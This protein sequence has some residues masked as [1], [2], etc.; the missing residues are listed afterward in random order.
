MFAPKDRNPINFVS[1]DDL[2]G[3]G[4]QPLVVA[5]H[6]RSSKKEED[7]LTFGGHSKG[8]S[9]KGGALIWQDVVDIALPTRPSPLTRFTSL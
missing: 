9:G 3:I 4:Y 8:I 2:H 7:R 5:G 1:K 6:D